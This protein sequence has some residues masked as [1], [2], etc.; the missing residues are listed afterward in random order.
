M[1]ERRRRSIYIHL[2]RSLRVPILAAFDVADT[3]FTC[4][5]RFAT[6]QPTQAL[7]ML[8]SVWVNE[9]AEHLADLL[10]EQAGADP[11]RRVKLALRRTLQREPT[12][13]EVE[14]GLA[15]M[16]DLEREHGLSADESLHYFCLTALNLNEFLY[17]D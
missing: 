7:G 3:E 2:K 4:P 17:L 14:R 10:R 11:G 1:E 13:A 8:N 5:V 6:T 9:Q 15:L 16:Q 12:A